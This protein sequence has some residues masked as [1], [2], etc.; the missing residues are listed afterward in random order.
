MHIT[1]DA[2]YEK[3]ILKPNE[4]L[5]LSEGSRVRLTITPADEEYDPLEAVIGICDS[6]RSDGAERHDQYI[7]GKLRQ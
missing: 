6:G 3:G 4:P 1:V 7:Y 5:Q 2:T